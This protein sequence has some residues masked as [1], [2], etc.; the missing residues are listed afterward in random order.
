VPA[1]A[2]AANDGVF[3]FFRVGEGERGPLELNIVGGAALPASVDR[4]AHHRASQVWVWDFLG[5]CWC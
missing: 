1:A 3:C 2:Q 4:G 5:Y